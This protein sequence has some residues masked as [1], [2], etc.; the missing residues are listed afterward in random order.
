M[1][2]LS[3]KDLI[4][5]IVLTTIF[6]ICIAIF[7]LN[8]YPINIISYL[9]LT[10]FL[11]GYAIISCLYPLNRKSKP[12]KQIFGGLTISLIITITFTLLTRY[13]IIA[14]SLSKFFIIIGILSIML[15]LVAIYL[16]RIKKLNKEKKITK[17]R[18]SNIRF[19]DELIKDLNSSKS[20][21]NYE[22]NE[23]LKIY[24]N[25][26]PHIKDLYLVISI[27]ILALMIFTISSNK[28][29]LNSILST[30]LS[31]V[32]LML[33][34]LAGYSLIIG[35]NPINKLSKS[36]IL[37][38]TLI[39]SIGLFLIFN[40]TFKINPI[41]NSSILIIS[42]LSIFTGI[43]C[44][45]STV[46]IIHVLK[47]NKN[48]LKSE[49]SWYSG[50]ES[51]INYEISKN[52]NIESE[53][54]IR[55]MDKP[56]KINSYDKVEEIS[57][58]VN[59]DKNHFKKRSLDLFLIIFATMICLSFVLVPKLNGTMIKN[60]ST[61]LL[62]LFLP[63][64]S[65]VAAL[66]PNK[67]DLD[68]YERLSLSFG[69]PLIGLSV[70][71]VINQI[72]PVVV[73]LT[74]ILIILSIFTVIMVIIAFGRRN[75]S[76]TNEET[77]IDS[78]K[79]KERKSTK[80]ETVKRQK[81]QGE[82]TLPSRTFSKPRFYSVDLIL[83]IITTVLT[84]IFIAIPVLNESYIRT[85][86]GLILIL[87]IPGY[88]LIAALFPK[89]DDLEGIE[90][91]ALSFGLSIAITP[92]IGLALNYTPF[93][94]KLTPILISLSAFT[95]LMV[96]FAYVRRRN[97]PNDEKFYVNFGGFINSI[98]NS[99]KGE[100]KSSKILSIILILTIGLAIFTTA[101]IIV[102]P[103]QGE[104][105]TE[106]YILGPGGKASD[107]PTNLT[108]GQNGS[109]IIGILNHENKN[110]DYHL[111][112]SSDGAVMSEQNI[113]ITNGNKTEI[114]YNFT[115]SSPGNKKIEFLLYKLPD[116]TNVYRSLHLFVNVT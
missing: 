49:N 93:G 64:Y 54:L 52:K 26:K 29:L 62:I 21:K 31:L 72:S 60:I 111:I 5:L 100:S 24:R 115:V 19:S 71:V 113:T 91:V 99:F 46:K 10:M 79:G 68:R 61:I 87:F 30:L 116:T 58:I 7:P 51:L 28:Y 4:L 67:D 15:Y 32:A 84:A 44:L 43:M 8:D 53:E 105:F 2:T 47:M 107:Y 63:G 94:I 103:K 66:Y 86:L 27:T 34:L 14:L 70:G 25:K 17:K 6:T 42:I 37:L 109:V 81:V 102:K 90:R 23:N 108:V 96:L 38:L 45:I 3:S 89:K 50:D 20:I 83:I 77:T 18:N 33:F 59:G 22:K 65:L 98:K 114:P 39:S 85:I 110:V 73:G 97:L 11:P 88:S 101:Y 69:F 48:E 1:N 74:S 80:K 92:L 36:F 41:L 75:R 76:S 104:S 112:V 9:T 12:Y 56:K 55:E 57:T 106:F 82:E 40:F 16:N 35:I 78:N 95:L 13:K